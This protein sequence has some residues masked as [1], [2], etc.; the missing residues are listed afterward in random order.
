MGNSM[1]PIA[2]AVGEKYTN[3][4]SDLYKFFENDRI[5]ERILSNY[6]KDS[7]DPSDYHVLKCGEGVFITMECNQILSFYPSEEFEED[8]E[9]EDTWRESSVRIR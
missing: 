8:I 4:S 3:F 6:A 7:V 2:I 9:E 5:Q 1:I